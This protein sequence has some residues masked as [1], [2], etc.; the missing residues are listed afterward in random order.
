MTHLTRS[1]PPRERHYKTKEKR[2]ITKFKEQTTRLTAFRI[3]IEFAFDRDVVRRSAQRLKTQKNLIMEFQSH[4]SETNTIKYN[5]IQSNVE[6]L[7]RNLEVEKIP[8]FHLRKFLHQQKNK[9]KNRS[10]IVKAP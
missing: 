2:E 4:N 7:R 9:N 5:K 1:V 10:Q 8:F 3:M 6:T